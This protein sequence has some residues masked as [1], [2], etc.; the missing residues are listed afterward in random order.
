MKNRINEFVQIVRA[1]GCICGS[2]SLFKCVDSVEVVRWR[3]WFFLVNCRWNRYI[4][5]EWNDPGT[6]N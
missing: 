2:I 5:I 3:R 4:H 1:T 6:D